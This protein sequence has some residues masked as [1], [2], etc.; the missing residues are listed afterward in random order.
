MP[1][2]KD[3]RVSVII[4][5]YNSSRYILQCIK[6]VLKQTR[7]PKE[8]IICDDCSTDNSRTLLKRFIS[9]Y[10]GDVVLKLLTNP[11]NLG[12]GLTRNRCATEATGDYLLF[13][14]SDVY[15]DQNVIERFVAVSRKN[16][17]SCLCGR[18]NKHGEG[19]NRDSSYL[20]LRNYFYSTYSK[21]D[22]YRINTFPTPF[23]FISRQLFVESRGFRGFAG[24]GGEEY[25]LGRRL[26]GRVPFLCDTTITATHHHVPFLERICKL[27]KR[28][29][30]YLNLVGTL[31]STYVSEGCGA[32]RQEIWSVMLNTLSAMLLL[33]FLVL[34]SLGRFLSPLLFL[35]V[36][37]LAIE[38]AINARFYIFLAKESGFGIF[39]HYPAHV[40][41]NVAIGMFSLF[42]FVRKAL[43]SALNL[44]RVCLSLV[45]DTS[46]LFRPFPQHVVLYVTDRCNATCAHC[47]L[48]KDKCSMAS[49]LSLDELKRMFQHFWPITYLAITGGEPTL[50]KDLLDIIRLAKENTSVTHITLHTN[51]Y[52]PSILERIAGTVCN[53]H[54][55]LRFHV[56]L[57][58]DHLGRKHDAIRGLDRSFQRLIHSVEKL[59]QLAASYKNLSMECDTVISTDNQDSMREIHEF[60]VNNLGVKHGVILLRGNPRKKESQDF[61]FSAY[62]SIVKAIDRDKERI[63]HPSELFLH[64]LYEMTHHVIADTV[65]RK[66]MILP[67]TAGV[68]SITL[69]PD[70]QVMPCEMRSRTLGNLRDSGYDLKQI[71]NSSASRSVVAEIKNTSCFCTWECIIPLN[72]AFSPRCYPEYLLRLAKNVK[73][74][75]SQAGQIPP[76]IGGGATDQPKRL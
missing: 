19:N 23:G 63:E 73:A 71:L 67:C 3:Y 1:K 44:G 24:A 50:R 31:N 20:A 28:V 32:D 45:R 74:Y 21:K 59:K 62:E 43:D 34:A 10:R 13:I 38:A 60:V 5:C 76:A 51:G 18:F 33:P 64:T 15:L 39:R 17:G 11:R 46:F 25:E 66:K 54:P 7:P 4:P 65:K 9:R 70:G 2:C 26:S 53:E 8:V 75:C 57:S 56:S 27:R 72:I 35:G 36:C 49:E 42:Y 37:S 48:W 68:K 58:L 29:P 40:T 12:A 22:T 14:D 30:V 41:L 16:P 52:F 69:R 55:D 6:C 47:F 61:S